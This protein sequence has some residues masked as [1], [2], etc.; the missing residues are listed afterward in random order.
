[1]FF[2]HIRKWCTLRDQPFQPKPVLVGLV[3]ISNRTL[4]NRFWLT[5]R[6]VLGIV[7]T[8]LELS[9]ANKG[10]QVIFFNFHVFHNCRHLIQIISR[11]TITWSF[12]KKCHHF[13]CLQSTVQTWSQQLLPTVSNHF[14]LHL[15]G[16]KWLINRTNR[17]HFFPNRTQKTQPTKNGWSQ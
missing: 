14:N 11:K 6:L 2:Q 4:F 3:E 16:F 17:K 10:E 9:W 7:I 12:G 8:S 13:V 15:S 1:M 5:T